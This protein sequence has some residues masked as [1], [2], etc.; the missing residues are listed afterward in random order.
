LI[1]DVLINERL[2][3]GKGFGG[4]ARGLITFVLFGRDDLWVLCC[5][6][7]YVVQGA[8]PQQT[9]TAKH[10]LHHIN[11]LERAEKAHYRWIIAPAFSL[12]RLGLEWTAMSKN[13]RFML[14]VG[15]SVNVGGINGNVPKPGTDCVD[16]DTRAKKVRSRRVS[17]GVR[18]DTLAQQRLMPDCRFYNISP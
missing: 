1:T 12:R 3:P 13:I 10:D 11:T 9:S 7:I 16:I 8:M 6:E 4:T 18:T 14:Q 15:F 17:D 5:A 2:L